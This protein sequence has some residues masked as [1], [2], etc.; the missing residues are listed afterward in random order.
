MHVCGDVFLIQVSFPSFIAEIFRIYRGNNMSLIS[1]T[2]VTA[3]MFVT[4]PGNK[5]SSIIDRRATEI[6]QNLHHCALLYSE[7]KTK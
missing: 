2:L 5:A 6:E 3:V 1:V 7:R 4:F